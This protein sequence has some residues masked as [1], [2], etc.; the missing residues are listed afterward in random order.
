VLIAA[1]GL[2]VYLSHLYDTAKMTVEQM[3][4]P[5]D[6]QPAMAAN[7][8]VE[9][10]GGSK[11]TSTPGP[12][13][14]KLDG[15]QPSAAVSSPN[16]A[17]SAILAA[18]K[19]FT[20][21]VLGVDER[22]GDA[23]R[24]D[25]IVVMAVN[26]D[27][28]SVMLVSIPRD[29]RTEIVGRGTVDKINHSYAFGGSTMAV[30]T[31][32]RLLDIRI[33]YYVRTKM[34]GLV[35]LIDQMGGIHVENDL[36][37]YSE[38]F[39]FE[40]GNIQLN[41]EEALVFTRMR[42]QDPQGDIGRAARQ[43]KVLVGLYDKMKSFSGLTELPHILDI[44]KSYVK[45]NLTWDDMNAMFRYYRPKIQSF[46]SEVLQ[47]EGVMIDAVYYYAVSEQEKRRL[48]DLIAEQLDMPNSDLTQSLAKV[49]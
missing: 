29:T 26:P 2:G 7:G 17:A 18:G 37:L 28:H 11:E 41:G 34:E 24:A 45:T 14:D 10:S 5:L 1:G 38:D 32:E 22:D 46:T 6:D 47:G 9:S 8:K 48:H 36:D 49:K 3:Y 19:P 39:P 15:G 23:G 33:D 44:L 35:D 13:A 21:L 30:R 4:E 43:R 12:D 40:Y 27:K 31:V 20:L 16:D 25:S 42:K